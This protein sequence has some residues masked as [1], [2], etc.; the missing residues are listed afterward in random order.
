[1]SADVEGL[2]QLVKSLDALPTKV[3]RAVLSSAIRG[4]LNAIQKQMKSE[5]NPKVKAA[6]RGIGTR[7][8]KGEQVIA[9]VGVGVGKRKKPLKKARKRAS[10]GGVGIGE[11]NLHWC[12]AG[13]KK[14]TTNTTEADRGSM[15]A[16]DPQLAVRAYKK[17]KGK[18]LAEMVRLGKK[19]FEREVARLRK[20]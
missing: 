13:T 2:D 5:L 8:K 3:G 7:F 10:K 1:M 20:G 15:P 16:M 14:R 17:A 18:I 6:R 9:K 4:G 11:R 12:V 19:R